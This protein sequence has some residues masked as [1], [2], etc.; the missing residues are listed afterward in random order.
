M[1]GGGSLALLV[2]SS[3]DI[4]GTGGWGVGA[5]PGGADVEGP[6]CCWARAMSRIA[7]KKPGRPMEPVREG[8]HSDHIYG[9]R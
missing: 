5:A 4:E 3:D 7:A 8:S 1:R 2:A 6:G 9:D